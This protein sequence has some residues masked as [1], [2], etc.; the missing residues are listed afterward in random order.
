MEYF[1]GLSLDEFIKKREL[2]PFSNRE[3]RDIMKQILL[4]IHYMHSLEVFHRDLKPCKFN[5]IK[6]SFKHNTCKRIS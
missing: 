1:E 2:Q 5:P 4:A 3:V 6:F